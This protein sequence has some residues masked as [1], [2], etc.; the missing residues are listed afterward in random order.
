MKNLSQLIF[1][2]VLFLTIANSTQA[3]KMSVQGTLKNAAGISVADGERQLKFR[4]YNVATGGTHLWEETGTVNVVGGIYSYLLGTDTPLPLAQFTNATTL[5]LG[6]V[7]ENFELQPR[8]ELTFAPYALGVNTANR[9]V[10]SGAVGD[11]KHSILNPTEFA[12]VNGDCWVPM[13]GRSIVGSALA[14]ITG[15]TNVPNGGGLFIRSQEF[16]NSTNFDEDRTWQTPIA[17]FQ[18]EELR[19]HSHGATLS[20]NASGVTSSNGGHS[21]TWSLPTDNGN[22]G[23]VTGRSHS[24]GGS[25]TRNTSSVGDHNHSVTVSGSASGNTNNAGGNETRPDNL[26]FWV[27]IRVN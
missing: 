26:N 19:S 4:I 24:E 27:Y 15:R 10:C 23:S 21:H 12:Q 6:I 13:D 3:Q 9:V 14:T 8:T 1:S 22:G 7:S 18:S 5:Y 11:I 20:V 16:Q 2:V 25:Q 17:S